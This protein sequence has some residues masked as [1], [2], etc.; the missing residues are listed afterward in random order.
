M[1]LESNICSKFLS[2]FLAGLLVCLPVIAKAEST[3][4]T[5]PKPLLTDLNGTVTSLNKGESAPYAGI[6]LDSEAT[7][8]ILTERKYLGLQYEL[9]LDLEIKKINAA[10]DLKLGLL[11]ARFDNLQGKHVVILNIKNDEITR[12]QEIVKDRPNSYSEWWLA[13]GVVIGIL[14]S[15]GVFYAAVEVN[16]N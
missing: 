2:I 10:H 12:L 6:L 7:A 16:K 14:V 11:Q 15:I 9:K 13:G 8:K 4:Q 3:P 1:Y 5:E